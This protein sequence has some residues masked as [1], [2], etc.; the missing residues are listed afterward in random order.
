MRIGISATSIMLKSLFMD[1]IHEYTDSL[2]TSLTNFEDVRVKMFVFKLMRYQTDFETIRQK[3]ACLSK[4]PFVLNM[5]LG[6]LFK[7]STEGYLGHEIDIFHA[8]DHRIPYLKDT[9]VVANLHDAIPLAFPQWSSNTFRKTK[10]FFLR[11]SSKWATRVICISKTAQK[12]V[13][14]YYNVPEDLTDVVYLAPDELYFSRINQSEK[15]R[16]LAKYR[17]YDK[18]YFL[19]VGTIQP[20]KNHENLIKA[21]NLLPAAIRKSIKLV[22]VGNYG[23]GCPHIPK[24]LSQPEEQKEIIWLQALPKSDLAALYQGSQ[25]LIFPSLHEG[26]GMS[27]VEAFASQAPVIASNKSCIPE[28]AGNAAVLIDPCDNRAI[29]NAMKEIVLNE[30]LKSDLIDKGFRRAKDFSWKKCTEQT[31]QVYKKALYN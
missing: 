2:I 3:N 30:K 9:P 5:L 4:K 26:F 10:N 24:M 29:S 23:W 6:Q 31:I 18:G 19:N 7:Y 20:R 13:I 14:Q 12:E 1:G 16:I 15:C 28:I 17:L 25:C 27:V 22:L 11:R 21:Y 8:T